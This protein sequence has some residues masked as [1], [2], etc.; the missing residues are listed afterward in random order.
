[1]SDSW[2]CSA[3]LRDR[4]APVRRDL[5]GGRHFRIHADTISHFA[6]H[7]LQRR[8]NDLLRIASTVYAVDRIFA[9]N[10]RNAD[11]GWTRRFVVEIEVADCRFWR[12]SN[13]AQLLSECLDFLTGDVWEFRFLDSG[14]S[15]N[16][17]HQKHLE[18]GSA[19]Q[20]SPTV[21]LYSGGLDSA[22][23]LVRRLTS[24]PNT[25]YQPVTVWH[26]SGLRGTVLRQLE[27]LRE[28]T[29]QRLTPLVAKYAM[30]RPSKLGTEE[31][32]QRSRSFLFSSVGAVAASA[33]GATRVEVYESGVG[34]VNLPL[35]TGML[36]SRATR[37]CHPHF[38][39]TFSRLL[40]DVLSHP[41]EIA[42]PYIHC[43]K[44]EVARAL[45]EAGLREFAH[46]TISC[47]HYPL[48]EEKF[49]RC[50]LCPACLFRRVSLS[51][52]GIHEPE[53]IY[54]WD[55]FRQ[56]AHSLSQDRLRYLKAF[57]IQV[58]GLSEL[59]APGRVP[60][61]LS[62]HLHG[63]SVLGNGESADR[64]V[65]V[66][67]RYRQEWL[68]FIARGRAMNMEWAKLLSTES[69]LA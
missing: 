19:R 32:T 63:T 42:L 18:F 60:R 44:G 48:R 46:S 3:T 6:C 35:Q 47:V 12:R 27:V 52:A 68:D 11:D 49:K 4:N 62:R 58:N 61:L 53:N 9:R 7:D 55:I 54:K 59:D 57:V 33:V 36:G 23:G 67:R 28:R 13:V 45:L 65:D 14:V 10:R 29:D 24:Q 16:G 64:F 25:E 22:A 39:Q 50:G 69:V 5:V 17:K 31:T 56:D 30:I 8:S 1:M 15:P 43:T 34:A 40:S 51:A 66:Y 38:F 37:S 21:C 26:R 41:L 2:K 20:R